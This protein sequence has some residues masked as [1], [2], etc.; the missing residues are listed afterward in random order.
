LS[1]IFPVNLQIHVLVEFVS[2]VAL[3]GWSIKLIMVSIL[4]W[5]HKFKLVFIVLAC[6]IKTRFEFLS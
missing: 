3:L 4:R 5:L 2:V 6:L 1:I